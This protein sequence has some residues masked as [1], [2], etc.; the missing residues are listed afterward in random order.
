MLMNETATGKMITDA[1]LMM[2]GWELVAV[3]LA[4]LYLILAMKERIECWYAALFST[5]IYTVIFWDVN[6][7]MESALQVYYLFMAV[8]GWYQWRKGPGQEELAIQTWGLRSHVLTFIGLAFMVL[9]SGY[10]LSNNTNAAWPYVDSFTTWGSVIT[11]YMV[12]KKVLENWLYWLVIDG[13]SI[14]LYIDRELYLTAIL[15][16]LYLVIVC[17][18]YRQ[19]TITYRRQQNYVWR[20]HN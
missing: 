15:F 7:L 12:T 10:L 17:F 13:I 14:F 6:L 11:T 9:I 3:I 2:S 1:Y 18:G 20:L 5:A 16:A 8:F 4:L 19:W